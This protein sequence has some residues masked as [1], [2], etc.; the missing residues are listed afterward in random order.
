MRSLSAA[1]MLL[2]LPWAAFAGEPAATA[3]PKLDEVLRR[4][5]ATMGPENME[6]VM[7]MTAHR[8][9]GTS[10][11]Y[12]MK[13]LKL[14]QDKTRLW[15]QEPAAV[16][17]QEILRQ[18]ENNWI[19]MPSLKRAI[20]LANRESFQ[21]GDFN[22]A[23]VLRVNYQQDYDGTVN[24]DPQRPDAWLLELK[25]KR[26]EA[27]YDRIRLWVTRKDQLPIKGEYYTASG[28]LLRSADFSDVKSIGKLSRPMR[29]TMKNMINT[30]RYSVI[31]FDSVNTQVN[32][33]SARFV[34]DDLGR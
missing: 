11:T 32:P 12:K 3:R 33:P 28:K 25:A 29:I 34:L 9:D 10:R 19:Y 7:A 6:A 2:C 15:F 14:G 23:D 26:D 24:E 31:E 18:G 1:L 4:Y 21:G 16:R 13:L 17:G 27:A 8:D 30:Q 20:R 22:N 5:D